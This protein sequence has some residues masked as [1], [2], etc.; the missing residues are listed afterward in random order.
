MGLAVLCAQAQPSTAA[1]GYLPGGWQCWARAPIA[2]AA[3]LEAAAS[4]RALETERTAEWIRRRETET[5]EAGMAVRAIAA[6]RLRMDLSGGYA[7]EISTGSFQFLFPAPSERFGGVERHNGAYGAATGLLRVWKGFAL[8]AR[9]TWRSNAEFHERQ[10]FSYGA[11][12][13][14]R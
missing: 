3:G 6:G 10:A 7:R 13:E 1:A 8:Q 12:W 2:E 14:W 4:W 9:Y 5:Y 11:A